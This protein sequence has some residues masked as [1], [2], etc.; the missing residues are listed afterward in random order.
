MVPVGDWAQKRLEHLSETDKIRDTS[1]VGSGFGKNVSKW[2]GRDKVYPTNV[3][4]MATEC[5]NRNHSAVFPRELP[6][7]FIKLFTQ[8]GDRV[9]DPF[10]GSGTVCAVAQELG[11]H[12][13]G[14]DIRSDYCEMA[15]ESV[16]SLQ[17][18]LFETGTRYECD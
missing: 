2:L 1:R 7:W 15:Q 10:V 5:S 12:A 11:R 8:E 9:L 17:P 18:R 16:R 13:V 14:I 3:L 4:H 6:E